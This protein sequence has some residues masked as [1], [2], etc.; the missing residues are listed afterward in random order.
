MY[1]WSVCTRLHVSAFLGHECKV[2]CIKCFN[3][4]HFWGLFIYSSTSREY[5][6]H[7][8]SNFIFF[9]FLFIYFIYFIYLFCVCVCVCVCSR[10]S[11][12][13]IIMYTFYHQFSLC[14]WENY[15]IPITNHSMFYRQPM[16]YFFVGSF[17]SGTIYPIRFYLF[18]VLSY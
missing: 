4:L 7:Y 15:Q 14:F 16:S 13:D 3:S 18:S 9:I 10:Y 1:A 2:V 5:P 8:A 6:G 11:T 17:W 12:V